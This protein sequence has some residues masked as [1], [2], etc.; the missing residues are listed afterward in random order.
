MIHISKRCSVMLYSGIFFLLLVFLAAGCCTFFLA[1]RM[2]G[3]YT[4]AAPRATVILDAGHGGIDGGAVGVNG[5]LEKDLN[6]SV[7]LLLAELLREAGVDVILTRT[8]DVLLDGGESGR[9]KEN[10]LKNRLSVA[11]S[12]PEALFISIHMNTY[13]AGSCRGFEAYYANTEKSRELAACIHGSVKRTLQP[14]NRRTIRAADSSIYLL[15]NAVG[16]AVLLECGFLSNS[17]ECE[18]LCEKDY[19]KELCFAIFCGIME[20]IENNKGEG[21]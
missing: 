2:A 13:P 9:R 14:D 1:H 5:A 8:E 15:K 4:Q 12:H 18:S 20:H 6:L 7:T 10:D 17:E 19:Q 16:S 21:L 3:E 11:S